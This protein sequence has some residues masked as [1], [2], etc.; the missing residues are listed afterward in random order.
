MVVRVGRTM[1]CGARWVLVCFAVALLPAVVAAKSASGSPGDLV[2]LPNACGDHSRPGRTAMSADGRFV[3]FVCSVGAG[4]EVFEDDLATGTTTVI[5]RAAG[6]DGEVADGGS[7]DFPS[8]SADGRF[9]AFSSNAD[10][11]ARDD[12]DR[13][14]D[15]FVRDVVTGTTTLVSRASGSSGAK[16]NG[17]SLGELSI[18]AD[19]HAV[20]FPSR[21]SNLSRADRDRRSDVFVRDLASDTTTLVSRASGRR[22]PKSNRQAAA[23]SM[24]GTGR[25]VAFWSDASNLSRADRDHRAAVF[26]R[27][28]ATYRTTLVSRPGGARFAPVIAANGRFVAFNAESSRPR[29]LD[30][31]VRDLAAHTTTLVTRATGADAARANGDSRVSSISGDGRRVAF[32]SSA[33]NLSS[34]DS[35][36]GY[37]AYVR[38]LTTQTTT[39]VSRSGASG[40]RGDS[41]S[42]GGS[43]SGDGRW[44]AFPSYAA[45][46]TP[47]DTPD[48]GV[49]VRDLGPEG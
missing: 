2:R 35:D 40:P 49:F 45:N 23:P 21:A 3:A 26:V 39:L 8:V 9:V 17:E 13:Q 1:L 25:A 34:S 47:D 32:E 18:S 16:G 11:L 42:G 30:I 6:P 15:V 46:L 27:D 31:F 36:P 12:T 41:I 7:S 29:Q 14:F 5:S 10:N 19:G 44:I 33:R 20:A 24:S 43:L 37:D 4:R 28:L 48:G 38:D 22:G